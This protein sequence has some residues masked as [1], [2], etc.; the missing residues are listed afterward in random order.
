MDRRRFTKALLGPTIVGSGCLGNESGASE[1]ADW[2]PTIESDGPEV[3][4]GGDA[5]L[6]IEATQAAGVTLSPP[7]VEGVRIAA[8]DHDWSPPPDSIVDTYPQHWYWASQQ[9]VEGEFPVSADDGVEP[10][11]YEY[12]ITVFAADDP[13]GESETEVLAIRVIET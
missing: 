4:P 7:E 12:G 9:T 8:N 3:P 13:D 2:S 6:T 5:T 10:G 1:D 11:E